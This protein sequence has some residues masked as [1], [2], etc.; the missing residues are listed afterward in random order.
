MIFTLTLVATDLVMR[1]NVVSCLVLRLLG[2]LMPTTRSWRSSS[3]PYYPRFRKVFDYDL[4]QQLQAWPLTWIRSTTI[5][6][7]CADPWQSPVNWLVY[8][9]FRFCRICSRSTSRF[10]IDWS[11]YSEETIYK[12]A[13]FWSNNRLHK[14]Q[15]VILEVITNELWNSR[16][17]EVH[18]ELNSHL[19]LTLKWPKCQYKRDC[20]VFPEYYL[21]SIRC[22]VDAGIRRSCPPTWTSTRRC[23]LTART[24]SIL[25]ILKPTN[26]SVWWANRGYNGWIEVELEDG[27]TK[28]NRYIERALG[29]RC[30]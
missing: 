5:Q 23:T 15:P 2:S 3:Y 24:T 12:V 18:V 13:V 21:F 17:L 29:R 10:A 30:R 25:T 16:G 8:Q 1:S 6:L 11:K 27:T 20:L 9:E 7:L 14:Q 22:F 19:L 4:V 26:F 28:K